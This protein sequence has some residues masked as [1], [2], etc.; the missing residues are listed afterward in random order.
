LAAFVI[1]YLIDPALMKP[2]V[3]TTGG[4][5]AVGVVV[6]METIGFLWISRIV[7]FKA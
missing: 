3:T 1:L 2:M 4:W 7:N 6:V 5:I